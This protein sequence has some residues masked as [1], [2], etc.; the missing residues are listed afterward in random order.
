MRKAAAVR[1]STLALVLALVVIGVGF[2]LRTAADA[3]SPPPSAAALLGPDY[4][5]IATVP[6]G[7]V[8]PDPVPGAATGT[9]TWDCGRNANGHRNTANV[10]VVPG[11]PGPVHHVHD[12]VGNLSTDVDSTVDSLVGGDTTCANGDKSTYYWPVL[13]TLPDGHGEHAAPTVGQGAQP[14]APVEHLGEIQLPVSFTLT[15]YGNPRTPV[16]PMP[17]LLR[18]TMGDAVAITNGGARARATWTC[19]DTPD[20]RTTRYPVCGPGRQVVRVFDFPSCWDGRRLDSADHRQH[21]VFPV[22][23]GGCPVATFA[24]PRLRLVASYDLPPGTRYQIDAF[25]GQHNSPLTDHA[26]FVNLFPAPLMAQVVR[27][28]NAGEVCDDKGATAG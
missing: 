27:C 12:Y 24:V 4:V 16:I 18:A 13:R 8:D 10:V 6:G 15:F 19:S 20:R 17:S 22:A 1:R 23:G 14:G 9:Y 2:G 28:L 5:D 26:F 21:L 7:Q 11:M 3:G 25:D